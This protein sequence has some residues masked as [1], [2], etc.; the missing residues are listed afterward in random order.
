MFGGSKKRVGISGFIVAIS[1]FVLGSSLYL[2]QSF[3]E[4]YEL[5]YILGTNLVVD[6]IMVHFIA[7]HMKRGV[8][9]VFVRGVR[10]GILVVVL[11]SF[12]FLM[13]QF[14]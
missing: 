14:V 8:R 5:A 1:P 12:T 10:T 9:E 13:F 4:L 11:L 2:T 3:L 7:A 6:I